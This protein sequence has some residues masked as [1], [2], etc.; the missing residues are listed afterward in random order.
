M[1]GSGEETKTG[2]TSLLL[3]Y[4]M[5]ACVSPGSLPVRPVVN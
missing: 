1:G 5:V 4:F 3:G 2:E